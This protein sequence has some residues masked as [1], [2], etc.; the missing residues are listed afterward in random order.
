MMK[1]VNTPETSV[2]FYENT[3]QNIQEDI[4]LQ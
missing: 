2:T 4:H 3:R 1:A